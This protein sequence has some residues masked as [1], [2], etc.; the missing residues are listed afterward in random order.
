MHA[1]N[2]LLLG[3]HQQGFPD[4][5]NATHR[6]LV[7]LFILATFTVWLQPLVISFNYMFK[8]LFRRHAARWLASHVTEQ[9]R[10]NPDPTQ[11]KLDVRLT[12]ICP[13]VCD[14]VARAL[15]EISKRQDFI[16]RGWKESLMGD[17]FGL[18]SEGE[19]G[20]EYK[21]AAQLDWDGELV[22]RASLARRRPS[23]PSFFFRSTWTGT[24]RRGGGQHVAAESTDDLFGTALEVHATLCLDS[25]FLHGWSMARAA[26]METATA[27]ARLMWR[28]RLSLGLQHRVV[29]FDVRRRR[30]DLDFTCGMCQYMWVVILMQSE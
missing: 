27:T 29:L 19:E 23:W 11:I 13:L 9:L 21:I 25:H 18:V 8:G 12:I 28:R 16:F 1:T 6:N 30:C 3:T 20:A 17:A 15:E 2:G 7:L 26:V 10:Q 5:A 22:V 14:W 24:T 4:W